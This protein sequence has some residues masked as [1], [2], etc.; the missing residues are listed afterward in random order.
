MRK[1]ALLAACLL[2]LGT[3]GL[4]Q[5]EPPKLEVPRTEFFIG[6][7]YQYTNPDQP[8]VGNT[9]LNGFAFETSHYFKKSDLGL[10]MDLGHQ[11]NSRVDNTG[12]KYSRSTYLIGPTY[13]F[14]NVG[15]WTANVHALVGLDHSVYTL[16][17]TSTTYKLNDTGM[18]VM[19]GVTVDG[20]LSRRLGIR[21]AQVDYVIT[22]HYSSMQSGIRYTGGVVIRF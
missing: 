10:T 7:A 20:N 6:Y 17:E 2:M 5:L 16:T 12:I 4:A 19:T 18:A 14:H 13:R 3:A 8:Q 15:F 22:D 11:A 21:L 1:F 9:H